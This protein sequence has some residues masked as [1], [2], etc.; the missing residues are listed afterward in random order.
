MKMP[1]EKTRARRQL[2]NGDGVRNI[3]VAFGTAERRAAPVEF[4]GRRTLR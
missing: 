4:A 3:A 2:E 1:R